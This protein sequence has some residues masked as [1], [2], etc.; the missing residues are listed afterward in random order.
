MTK[1]FNRLER[2]AKAEQL[3]AQGKVLDEEQRVLLSSKKA[4]EKSVTE[5]LNIKQQLEEVAK[6]E[7]SSKKDGSPASTTEVIPEEK[8]EEDA[9]AQDATTFTESAE[10]IAAA[11]MTEVE[12]PFEEPVVPEIDL[13]EA[14]N[15]FIERLIKALHVYERYTHV[16]SQP[17]PDTVMYFGRTLLGLTSISSFQDTL[18][19]SIRVAGFYLHVSLITIHL[20]IYWMNFEILWPSRLLLI[21]LSPSKILNWFMLPLIIHCSAMP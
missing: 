2:I 19:N 13:K 16:T 10:Q 21:A 14:F 4:I 11:T 1:Y 7:E 6:L 9:P 8:E 17:L 5:L 15:Q 3:L 20:F 12:E 18:N